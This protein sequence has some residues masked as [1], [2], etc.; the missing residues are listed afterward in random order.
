[1]TGTPADLEARYVARD[2]T[3]LLGTRDVDPNHPQ[4]DKTCA[5]EA[6]GPNRYARGHGYFA[7]LQAREGGRLAHR[8][9]DVP[10]VAHQ[11]GRMLTSACAVAAMFDTQDCPESP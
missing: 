9:H 10:G 4:L 7:V 3:Y 1:M 6:Q 8:L 5:G 11:G 2:V